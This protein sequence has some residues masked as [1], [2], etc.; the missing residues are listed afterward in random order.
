[1]GKRTVRRRGR[2]YWTAIVAQFE[3]GA[4]RQADFCHQRGLGLSAFQHWLYQ[5]RRERGAAPKAAARFVPVVVSATA[6]DGTIACKLRS[7]T[8]EVSFAALPP[9]T[10]VAE[11]LRL[12]DR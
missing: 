12:M 9:A 6:T 1:V 11:L 2:A 3:R 5:L 8:T 10:Y 7:G 4:E